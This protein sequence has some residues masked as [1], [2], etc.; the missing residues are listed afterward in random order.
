VARWL[1]NDLGAARDRELGSLP[2]AP[3]DFGRLVALV[4][5]GRL[6][7]AAGKALLAELVEKGGDPET[8]MKALG[9]EKVDD[10]ADVEAAV[11][12]A[13]EARRAEADRY[14]AGE[15]K[16]FGVLVGAAMRETGGA[17]DAALV[18]KVLEE[19]LG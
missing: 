3:D 9:L 10:R 2:L 16:L 7:P 17:A 19:K 4:D 12:R 1:L 8:R 5:A 13:L 15:K 11:A 18:R 14:R 6:T